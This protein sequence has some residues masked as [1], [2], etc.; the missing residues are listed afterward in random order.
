M[1]APTQIAVLLAVIFTD[2]VIDGITVIV[3]ELEVAGEPVAQVK[4]D[5][6]ITVTTSPFAKEL[7]VNIE[8]FV[9]AFAPFTC[10][11]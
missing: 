2:G 1:G 6:M 11:W 7:I 3:M 10:H 5:V 4:L 8:E 9:P